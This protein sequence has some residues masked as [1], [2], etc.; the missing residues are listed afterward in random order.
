MTS[1]QARHNYK[2]VESDSIVNVDTNKQEIERDKLDNNNPD[3]DEVNPYNEIITD[4]VEKGKCNY[5]A[6]EA[7]VNTQ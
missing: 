5:I 4:K 1:D 6:N 2:K 7:M 3:E